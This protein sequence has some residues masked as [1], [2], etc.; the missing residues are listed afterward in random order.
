MHCIPSF[1]SI[2]S[3]LECT[4]AFKTHNCFMFWHSSALTLQLEHGSHTCV[5]LTRACAVMISRA[6]GP[7]FGGS[8]GF[9]FFLANIISCALYISGCVEGI[10]DNFGPGGERAGWARERCG[11]RPRGEGES[12]D[13]VGRAQGEAQC[14]WVSGREMGW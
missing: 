8:I 13:R 1:L 6:L 5:S 9:L 14:C 12:V 11:S 10:T 7:E 2:P 4:R 3:F